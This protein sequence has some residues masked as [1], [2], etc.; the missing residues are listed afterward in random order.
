LG[1]VLSSRTIICLAASRKKGALCYAGKDTRTGDWIRPVST[2]GEHEVSPAHAI[3]TDGKLTAVGDVV[4]IKFV[5]HD[6]FHFQ[7]E[8]YLFDEQERWRKTGEEPTRR[9]AELVD[10]PGS[11]WGVGSSSWGYA[12][13]RVPEDEANNQNVSLYLIR[14]PRVRI[15]VG[16][17]GGD[18]ADANKRLV[19]ASFQYSGIPYTLQITDPVVERRMWAGDDRTESVDNVLLCVSLGG[20]FHG[21]AYKLVATIIP[22]G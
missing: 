6:P 3:N 16:R 7:H 21:Y 8:N 5:K 17:K 12:N 14:V 10:S 4:E 19:K 15:S 11:L 1:A 22:L 9:L 20:A 18:Y 2:H 13:N